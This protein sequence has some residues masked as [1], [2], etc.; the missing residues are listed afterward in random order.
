MKKYPRIL[1]IITLLAFLVKAFLI[2]FVIKDPEKFEAHDIAL[3][4]LSTG[5]M[6][7][8]LDGQM[9]YNYQFPVYPFL[10]FFIYKV[11][12]ADFH[13]ALLFNIVLS[14]VTV[15]FAYPVFNYFL[16]HFKIGL[17]EK[18]KKNISFLSASA[19]V[20][21]PPLVYYSAFIIH[22]F[23]LDLLLSFIALFA[24]TKYMDRPG[25]YRLWVV[26]L[27]IGVSILD[28]TT[29]ATLLFPLFLLTYRDYGWK[30]ATVI[31][32]KVL[33]IAMLLPA[34]WLVRNYG[35]YN[36]FSLNSSFG[37]NLWIGIQE[38]SDGSAY[39]PDGKTYYT[40]LTNNE[41]GQVQLLSPP[42]QSDYF[43][44][45]YLEVMKSDPSRIIR[46]Y[47][48][49]LKNFWWFRKGIG[50]AYNEKANLLIPF[51]KAF[52][53]LTFLFSLLALVMIGKRSLLLFSFPLALSL[54]QAIFY[55]ETRHRALIEPILIFFAITGCF[56]LVN[57]F[58]TKIK[59]GDTFN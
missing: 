24:I 1:Y 42:Q 21:Y 25:T 20:L 23:S 38:E 44:A 52:Y 19:I 45:K 29:M 31:S 15:F 54:V 57:K 12:G 28:R 9:N 59:D 30:K 58:R 8:F 41:W 50:I 17:G 48:I 51:Y 35:I 10:L 11:F 53:V 22:P 13:V 56:I 3:N 32:I 37:Q 5:E 55:V 40:T 7:Y 46:M 2:L 18:A 34:C 49:K 43:V 16:D 4:M 39:M 14:S 26:A 47:C 33:A 36:R 6:K 27:I